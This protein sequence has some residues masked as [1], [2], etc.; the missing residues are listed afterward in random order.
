MAA[1]S[2]RIVNPIP[3]DSTTRAILEL[4]C[5]VR[6][7]ASKLEDSACISDLGDDIVQKYYSDF[8]SKDWTADDR[9]T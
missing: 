7:G 8:L 3:A 2:A 4:F 9:K 1:S 5:G 6:V